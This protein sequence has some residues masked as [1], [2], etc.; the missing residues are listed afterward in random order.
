MKS[1]IFKNDLMDYIIPLKAMPRLESSL[2]G[3]CLITKNHNE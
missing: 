2:S 3:A 1:Q